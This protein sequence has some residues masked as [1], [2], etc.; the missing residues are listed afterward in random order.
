M[1]TDPLKSAQDVSVFVNVRRQ[2]RRCH[3]KM[4]RP[5]ADTT[6]IDIF[7]EKLERFNWHSIYFGAFD[8]EFLSRARNNPKLKIHVRSE[9]SALSDSDP[10][11]INEILY[12]IPTRYVAWLNP[13]HVFLNLETARRA[14]EHFL[15]IPN[16]SLTSVIQKKGW[17]YTADGAPIG[18]DGVV[19]DTSL[20]RGIFEVAHAF[21]IYEK[22]YMLKNKRLWSN[23]PGDPLLY[24]I[25]EAQAQDIDTEEQFDLAELMY[26][27]NKRVLA[28]E[29]SE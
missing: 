3:D 27:N 29:I 17:F 5:F 4:V 15:T 11:L 22:D 26:K 7:L 8:E 24:P 12:H 28:E 10:L 21:H 25:P 13:C 16:R 18:T 9:A 6:L 2:S 20:S 23:Q 14:I 1:V 19:L